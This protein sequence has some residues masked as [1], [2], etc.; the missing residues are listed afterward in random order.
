MHD[1]LRDGEQHGMKMQQV[2]D[3]SWRLMVMWDPL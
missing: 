2:S 3:F 1:G